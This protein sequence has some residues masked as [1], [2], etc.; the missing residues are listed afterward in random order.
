M[1]DLY[2][3]LLSRKSAVSVIGL[4]YVGMPLAIE[5]A[6]YFKV[7]GFDLNQSKIEEYK[8]GHDATREVGDEA[9]KESSVLFSSDAAILDEAQF[10][11]IAVPTPINMDKTPDFSPLIGA[12]EELGKHLRPGAVVVYESTVYPGATEEICAPC[13]EKT[14]GLKCGKDFWIGY[15]PERINPADKNHTLRNIKKVVS[16]LTPE[17]TNLI[18]SVY[19]KIIDAGVFRTSN[20]KTAEAIK[21]VENSQRDINIAFMNEIAMVFDLM[22]IDTSE[23]IDGMNTKWN[24]LGFTPGLVGGHCIGVDPY[25][26]TYNAENLGY[27]SQIILSGRKINDSMGQY[28]ADIAIRELVKAGYAPKNANVA[29]LGLTF[30]EN[31]PDIRN[32]KSVDIISRLNEYGIEPSVIDPYLTEAPRQVSIRGNGTSLSSLQNIDCIILAVAHDEFK[33]EL[34]ES[35]GVIFSQTSKPNVIIDVKSMLSKDNLIQSD[36]VYWSL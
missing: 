23:V 1:N 24:A 27:H 13:L 29:V 9:L 17:A 35:L 33:R 18:S 5:L 2:E 32:S 12:S 19:E 28:V 21:V 36:C 25:Y 8:Q 34:P 20:I 16:G 10:H 7:V 15:S 14:S 22:G 4:G 31:C 11:I 26:F 30:K 6:K 3:E